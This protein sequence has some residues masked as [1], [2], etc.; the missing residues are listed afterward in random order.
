MGTIFFF[1]FLLPSIQFSTGVKSSLVK[2]KHSVVTCDPFYSE[3]L[4]SNFTHS[5]YET[6][7]LV[8]LTF[9][10]AI[11]GGGDHACIRRDW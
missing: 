7:G 1:F 3:L 2:Y 8:W 4:H 5:G 6:G 11:L 10:L 9:E